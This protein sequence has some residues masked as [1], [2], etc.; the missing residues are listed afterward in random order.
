[1][2]RIR[3]AQTIS[4]F[5]LVAWGILLLIGAL[6]LPLPA[7]PGTLNQDLPGWIWLVM[8]VMPICLIEGGRYRL[9]LA[10]GLCEDQ[11]SHQAG[12]STASKVAGGIARFSQLTTMISSL[13]WIALP[14]IMASCLVFVLARS[15]MEGRS[16]LNPSFFAQLGVLLAYWA[17]RRPILNL[18]SKVFN[19]IG[20]GPTC[21]LVPGGLVFPNILN[22]IGAKAEQYEVHIGFNELEEVRDLSDAEAEALLQFKIGLDL[23]LVAAATADMY[24]YLKSEIPRP[25]YHV[26]TALRPG[27]RTLVLRGRDLFYLIAVSNCNPTELIAAFERHR[28]GHAAFTVIG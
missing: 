26:S 10:R 3:R 23:S 24:R 8:P 15:W 21:T 25:R 27:G 14:L 2:G 7:F 9:G 20:T 19:R 4:A 12:P 11:L 16:G 1:M 13:F 6:S 17:L 5:V 22:M 28:S 18:L